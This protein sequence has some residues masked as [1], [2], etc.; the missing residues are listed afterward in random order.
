[1]NKPK[2]KDIE[3]FNSSSIGKIKNTYLKK[4]KIVGILAIMSGCI[5]LILSIYFKQKWFD[6]ITAVIL[7]IFG[8]YFII[9]SIK[10]KYQEVN[11]YIHVNHKE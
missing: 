4:A 2:D 8:C 9:N 7:I 11:K 5:Y 3:A 10:I 1:M 6:Y